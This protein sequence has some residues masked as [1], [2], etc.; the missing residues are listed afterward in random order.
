MSVKSM[1]LFGVRDSMTIL[2]SF[3]LPPI[4]AQHLKKKFNLQEGHANKI[5]QLICP[6][7]MQIFSCPLHLYGLDIYN[8]PDTSA[9]IYTSGERISFI[10]QEYLKTTLAR[11]ARI[12]PAFGFGGVI[13]TEIRTNGQKWLREKYSIKNEL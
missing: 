10:K 6:V 12:L 8:R 11:M 3:S 7:A 1:G 9:K 4:I 2:A 5:S 13:N